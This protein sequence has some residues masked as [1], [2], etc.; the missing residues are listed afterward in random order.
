[1]GISLNS[2]RKYYLKVIVS[3]LSSDPLRYGEYGG[4]GEWRRYANLNLQKTGSFT[5]IEPLNA[6]QSTHT[7]F[8]QA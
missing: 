3:D 5:A 4:G 6:Y 1:M 8:S 7:S 2:Y